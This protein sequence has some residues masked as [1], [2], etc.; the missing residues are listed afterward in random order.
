MQNECS[1]VGVLKDNKLSAPLMVFSKAYFL[2]LMVPGT[3]ILRLYVVA[4]TVRL[5]SVCNLL[6]VLR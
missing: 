6:N 3:R 2:G 4:A 1:T 5:L